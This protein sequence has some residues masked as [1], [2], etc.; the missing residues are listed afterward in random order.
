MH[1]SICICN[2]NL[3]TVLWKKTAV[4]LGIPSCF[5]SKKT[6]RSWQFTS[7]F[8]SEREFCPCTRTP[9]PF[10][11]FFFFFPWTC[12]VWPATAL[13]K[14]RAGPMQRCASLLCNDIYAFLFPVVLPLLHMTILLT[15]KYIN[16]N[17]YLVGKI[18]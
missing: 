2:F 12:P 16:V 8:K 15:Q 17:L 1:F 3:C 9:P 6:C 11:F 5:V 14:Y 13:V 4:S 7:G 10:H 18:K